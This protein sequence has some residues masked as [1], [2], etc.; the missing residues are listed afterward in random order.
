MQGQLARIQSPY[1]KSHPTRSHRHVAFTLRP[2]FFSTKLSSSKASKLTMHSLHFAV[3]NVIFLLCLLSSGMDHSLSEQ[4]SIHQR[5]V[6][7]LLAAI[8][9]PTTSSAR[10]LALDASSLAQREPLNDI[11]P[12]EVRAFSQFEKDF[13]SHGI[14]MNP[15]RLQ[16]NVHSACDSH[17]HPDIKLYI[18]YT[19]T[20]YL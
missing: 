15:V 7:F 1:L 17:F 11:V 3:A 12:R 6:F 16:H 8:S 13:Q 18:S 14:K 5:A 10:G 2:F 20:Y 19:D 4:R 9:S